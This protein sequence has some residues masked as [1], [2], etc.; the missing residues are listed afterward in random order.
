M[1]TT[2]STTNTNTNT[3]TSTNV[4]LLLQMSY[5]DMIKNFST[6]NEEDLYNHINTKGK[7]INKQLHPIMMYNYPLLINT[8]MDAISIALSS[9]LWYMFR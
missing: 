7:S 5:P 1:T 4:D 3:C 9:V 6:I 8:I 2:T